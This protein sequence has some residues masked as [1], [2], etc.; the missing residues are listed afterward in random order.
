MLESADQWGGGV[1]LPGER[2]KLKV[3]RFLN[4]C[5][6]HQVE[7][8]A[9]LA[10]GGR[11]RLCRVQ[12][13]TP[14]TDAS[15]PGR[16]SHSWPPR[17]LRPRTH[18]L[19]RLLGMQICDQDLLFK[20]YGDVLDA[21]IA[22]LKSE[23]KFDAGIVRVTGECTLERKVLI[24]KD[25][26]TG[27][28]VHHADCKIDKGLAWE[29][30]LAARCGATAQ[31]G[32]SAGEPAD[33]DAGGTAAARPGLLWTGLVLAAPMALRPATPA[34]AGR[35]RWRS[36]RPSSTSRGAASASSPDSTSARRSS[37]R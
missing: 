33:S 6:G 35:R 11:L 23:G 19:C 26:S 15:R 29:E 16:V 31:R 37:T 25:A 14:G 36:C 8:G 34:L 4:R 2:A 28:E 1:K 10:P 24:H 13:T 22:K 3:A 17:S 30:A 27:G 32:G 20:Y 12:P 18:S 5:G 7:A 9:A 21:T